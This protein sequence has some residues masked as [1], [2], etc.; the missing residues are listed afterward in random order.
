[1]KFALVQLNPI[2]GDLNY[3]FNLMKTYCE[4]CAKDNVSFV[5]FSECIL[6]GYPPQDLLLQ[7]HFIK[8]VH[9]SIDAIKT[10]SITVPN[11]AICFGTPFQ[12]GS[13]LFNSACVIQN[14]VLLFQQYK[15]NLPQY[16][17]FDEKR[18]FSSSVTQD[19]FIFKGYRIGITICEDAWVTQS[20]SY[21]HNPI[22]LFHDKQ[23]D[24]LLNLSASPF[25]RGKDQIRFDLF[26]KHAQ[27][28]GVPV[29][30]VN[31]V[32]GNDQLIF[33]GNSFAV[34]A[35]GDVLCQLSSFSADMT[36]MSLDDT[37]K[38][39]G[40]YSKLAPINSIHDALVLGIRD[41]VH[42]TGFKDVVIGLSGGIDSAVTCVLAVRALGANH[43]RGISLPSQFSSDGSLIDAKALAEN[44]G[45]DYSV[46]SINAT[47][48][49]LLMDLAPMFN[50][51]A[52]DVTEENIQARSRGVLLMAIAN[53]FNSLV[54]ATG[55]KSE[56]AM[57]Y[58]TLYG[59]MCGAL[60]VLA[61]VLKTCVYELASC[62]NSDS[63]IIPDNSINKAPSA[64]LRPNQKDSD[65]LPSYDTLDE[66][67]TY[68][69]EEGLSANDIINHGYDDTLVLDVIKQINQN[70][71]KRFQAAMPL[72]I[73]SK[74]FGMGRRFPI[75]SKT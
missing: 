59:D 72:R 41:Y 25:E 71:Y 49:Q 32:G 58:C 54:L 35:F 27:R 48:N 38:S 51:L 14:G 1:M 43:V 20:D 33:D 36:V 47:Y 45:I 22:D 73:S 15:F 75:A 8:D 21:E 40:V 7:A 28:L 4:R 29:I 42:K 46:I 44:L 37:P 24:V 39:D 60:A 30:M 64:E 11:L 19:V 61:D 66:I 63:I 53:K 9:R 69:I 55:N 6:T 5:V 52:G 12:E 34:S 67:I 13:D 2:V 23:L 50:D 68:Y 26:S 18:Y 74:S 57:G 17:V 10:F 31:Q 56:L 70:E 62:I 3:N 65:S 16:D